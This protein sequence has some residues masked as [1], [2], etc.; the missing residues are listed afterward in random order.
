MKLLRVE[1]ELMTERELKN[2]VEQTQHV[3]EEQLNEVNL[4][5]YTRVKF[6]TYIKYA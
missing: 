1:D 2:R 4:Q 5:L 6:K 3:L